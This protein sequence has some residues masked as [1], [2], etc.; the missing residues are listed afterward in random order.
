MVFEFQPDVFDK[1][2]YS[3]HRN[4]FRTLSDPLLHKRYDLH[5]P[6]LLVLLRWLFSL[7]NCRC[8]TFDHADI[9]ATL[10]RGIQMVVAVLVARQQPR[11]NCIWCSFELFCVGVQS[12]TDDDSCSLPCV[13]C[14]FLPGTGLHE[15]SSCTAVFVYVQPCDLPESKERMNQL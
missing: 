8:S 2:F 10:L 14:T 12:Y 4:R 9:L 15:R 13:H 7:S 1:W 6:T 5:L 3:G 11:F